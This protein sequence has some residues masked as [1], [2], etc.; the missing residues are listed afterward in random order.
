MTEGVGWVLG[1]RRV[2]SG[3][4][5]FGLVGPKGPKRGLKLN[6]GVEVVGCGLLDYVYL[7]LIEVC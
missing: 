7:E 6:H 1:V 3:E 5:G 2:E 4:V